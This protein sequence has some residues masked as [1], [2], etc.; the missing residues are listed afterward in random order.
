M[1]D[2]QSVE[3]IICAVRGQPEG[4]RTVNHAINLALEYNAHLTFFLAI[5]LKFH[6]KATPTL[7]PLEPVYRQLEDLG[8]FSMLILCDE[9]RLRGLEKVDYVIR[10]GNV[11][12]QIRQIALEI[13]A[14]LMVMGRP[15]P[16]KGRVSVFTSQAFDQFVAELERDAGIR[17]IV[18][19][20]P[21]TARED[22]ETNGD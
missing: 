12:T 1:M 21:E 17:I 11:P 4:A 10:K 19:T 8:K 20:H 9:A 14:D 6:G 22:E 15:I 3:H 18:I 5:D 2:D 16:G 7:R 13:D